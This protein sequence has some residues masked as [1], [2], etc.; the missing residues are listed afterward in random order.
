MREWNE[1]E[2]E[3][4]CWCVNESVSMCQCCVIES[5]S[6]CVCVCVRGYSAY[7]RQNSIVDYNIITIITELVNCSS[8]RI[9]T[10]L[11]TIIVTTGLVTQ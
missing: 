4:W 3:R 7:Y 1:S 2:D 8:H 10:G 11:V 6:L 9:V 5:V